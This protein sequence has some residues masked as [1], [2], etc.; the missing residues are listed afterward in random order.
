MGIPIR[1]GREFTRSDAAGATPV[2]IINEGFARRFFPNT[3]PIGQKISAGFGDETPREIVGVVGDFKHQELADDPKPEMYVPHTQSAWPGVF[4]A[5][6]T[7]VEPE[8]LATPVQAAIWQIEKNAPIARVATM[9]RILWDAV[10][11]PR[12]NALLLGI[13]SAVALA[14]AAVGIYGVMS[15]ATA[16]RTHEIGIRLALGARTNNVLA[17]I[18]GQGMSLALVGVAIGLAASLALT[19]LMKDLLFSVKPA[20]PATFVFISL[21]LI[22]V[23]LLACWIPARRATKVDPMVAL[24]H[25]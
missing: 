14:L 22:G 11:H 24:R 25:E 19:R 6:R 1:G 10:A 18:I 9:R 13:F 21:L 23:A 20:D 5:V 7:S 4:L 12:F 17:L 2:V 15:Y 3:N 16:Q 8:S